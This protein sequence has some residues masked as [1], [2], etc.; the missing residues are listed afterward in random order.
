MSGSGSEQNAS[1]SSNTFINNNS[2]AEPSSDAI[3]QRRRIFQ[4]YSLLWLDE[5]MVETSKDYENVLTQLKT[6]TDNVNVFKQR[7]VCIDFLT[8][9]QEDIRLFLVVKDTMSQQ[10]MP[11]INDIPQLHGIYI[12]DDNKILPEE[13]IKNWQKIKSVHTN[14]DDL[15]QGLQLGIKQYH[16]DSIAI[17][18]ITANDIKSADN[19]NQLEP[20]FMYTQL[21][22][23]ILL[24]MKYNNQTIKDF[25]TYCR[26]NNFGSSVN[27]NLFEKEYRAQ[28]AIW[29]YTYP[30]FI[31]SML[32]DGLRTMDADIIITMGFFL[33]DVH[34]RI[35]QLY[36]HQVSTYER[37]SFVAYRGQGLLKSDFE[38]LQKTQG[39]LISFNNFLSTSRHKEVSIGYAQI[40]STVPDK[41]GILF[42]ML[43][44]PCI[45]STPFA[46]IENESHFKNEGEILFSMHTV[47]RVG[48]I[49][50]M[51]NNNQL[52]QVELQLTS[53]DDQQLRLLTD[54][55]RKE[56]GGTGWQ[57]LSDILLKIGQFNK[58]EELYNVLLEQTSDE[59]EKAI[60]YNQLGLVRSNQGDYE[61]AIW[62]Y[63]KALE[64]QQKTLPSNH[65]E[66]A[67]LYNNIGSVYA[68]MGEYTK[69]LSFFERALEINQKT[70]PS[71]HPKLAGPYNNIGLVYDRMGECSKALSFFEKALKIRQKTLP[72]NHP[73]LAGSYNNIGGVYANMGEYSKALSSHKKGLEIDQKTLPSSHPDLAL[74]YNNIGNVYE[75]MGE[76]SRALSFYEKALEIN[77][78]TLPSNHPGFALSYNNNGSVYEKIG[79][80]S[81]ALSFYEKGLEMNRKTLPSNHPDFAHSH[82]YIGSVYEKIG[83]YSKALSFFEKGLEIYQKTLP[84]NHPNLAGSYNNIGNVYASMGEY[85]KALSFFEKGLEIY[86]KTLPSNH[87]NLAGS[88]NNIGLVYDKMREYSK[89]LSSHEQALDIIQKTLPSNH[90]SLANSYN[91]IA[92]VYTMMGEYSKA[93]SFYEKDLEISQEALPS[94]HPDLATSYNNIALVYYS[95]KDYSKALS[96]FERALGIR[97]RA[98]PPNHPSIKDVKRD[99]ESVKKK[100]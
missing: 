4:N 77:Q 5:C 14:F 100:L 93:L 47:F 1:S 20:T 43:I 87:P 13:L 22:K 52:Y 35:Q 66:L 88:Y 68:S 16:Q 82:I 74:S 38:K 55:I 6:I 42:I 57:R 86:Q 58:A 23:E 28:S 54:R 21:F 71:N 69:A 12:F 34:E 30:S 94:N 18:F 91:N 76:H 29:W 27:I 99:I 83:E 85:T 63:E 89:A 49:E 84:S 64:I 92:L 17:S 75:K 15:Y 48:A 9:A 36:E 11:L 81:K 25:I 26:Q 96:Y 62:Y 78:K 79:E 70:L 10:I 56:V 40:A 41:M 32:N 3:Q 24:N 80:Y 8:D 19:L 60:Y 46:S 73:D 37:K 97:Q 51:D 39:G 50:Q 2:T 7:D 98:L 31:Y 65:H 33:R 95:M 53:D 67:T 61:K 45:K 59:G 90:P 72:S 44:D